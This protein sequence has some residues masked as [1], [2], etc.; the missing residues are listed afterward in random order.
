MP[1]LPFM[2]MA[3]CFDWFETVAAWL[4]PARAVPTLSVVPL[5]AADER[6]VC[7]PGSVFIPV[8]VPVSGFSL[9]L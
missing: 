8:P 5:I 2:L 6:A 9:R 4:W 1:V 7:A 3:R